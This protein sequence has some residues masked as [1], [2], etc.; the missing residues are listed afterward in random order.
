MLLTPPLPRRFPTATPAPIELLVGVEAPSS[1]SSAIPE[2]AFSLSDSFFPLLGQA[3][4]DVSAPHPAAPSP[5]PSS[6]GSR[7][8]GDGPAAHTRRASSH[9]APA[10]PGTDNVSSALPDPTRP[11]GPRPSQLDSHVDGPAAR[12]RH[13]SSLR[14]SSLPS[15]DTSV[16]PGPT[17]PAGPRPIQLVSPAILAPQSSSVP[18]LVKPSDS[19][20]HI[21]EPRVDGEPDSS[22]GAT[23]PRL[24]RQHVYHEEVWMATGVLQL[25]RGTPP[26]DTAE[27][28][29]R[30]QRRIA[31]MAAE[32]R[33]AFVEGHAFPLAIFTV[34]GTHPASPMGSTP[35]EIPAPSRRL[36]LIAHAHELGH[37]GVAKTVAKVRS[38]GY[39]WVG[40]DSDVAMITSRCVACIRDNLH[41]SHWHPAIA[42][43]IPTA[44]MERVHMD[45]LSLPRAAG[46]VP[47]EGIFLLVDAL[48]KWP[49]AIPFVSKGAEEIGMAYWSTVTTYGPP[50]VVISDNGA[51]FASANEILNAMSGIHG[52]NQRFTSRYR[53]QADGQAERFNRTII[54]VLRK[55]SGDT[56][57]L[58]H[59][60]LDTVLL[61]IR[62]AVHRSTRFSPF[63]LMFG[64]DW[65]PLR[66][67]HGLAL[68][69]E[70]DQDLIGD[71]SSLTGADRDSQRR[72]LVADP[73]VNEEIELALVNRSRLMRRQLDWTQR[74]RD[75]LKAAAV[76]QVAGQDASHRTVV[77]RLPKG[78]TVWVINEPR[79]NKID[80]L[81]HGPFTI[82][83]NQGG[84]ISSNY[85]LADPVSGGLLSRSV[86]RDKI[87]L[88]VN[89][90][91]T[92]RQ[93]ELFAGE[94]IEALI[95][96][97]D[98][99][100]PGPMP[101]GAAQGGSN[102]PGE[103]AVKEVLE[104]RSLRGVQELL[105][106]WVGYETPTWE[107]SSTFEPEIAA[108]LL[109][110]M[111][112]R[113]RPPRRP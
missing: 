71:S 26:E 94:E 33:A 57:Q 74:A 99:V 66:E 3:S 29:Q 8:L 100:E 112:A 64:R 111:A 92:R 11:A 14:A 104:A 109:R 17:Q 18:S 82:E 63:Q 2:S 45:L 98:H 46:P 65:N 25:L 36:A 108:E 6:L 48:S 40:L 34:P 51:E 43:P 55:L 28:P 9:R 113:S 58:W 107:P 83:A 76:S 39:W 106:R 38:A 69:W 21:P 59:T 89:I 88:S 49:V 12:T 60:W 30:F 44:I 81:F 7:S 42:L 54:A 96:R 105:V 90:P 72:I 62:T 20:G 61:V 13:A 67:F 23:P 97:L 103:F 102:A 35:L 86:P 50:R 75:N 70:I 4:V 37:F 110:R 41:S 24:L 77:D 91:L 27:V 84:E 68:Q 10:L 87:Y 101:P 53:P 56:P 93:A 47:Y 31:R 85:I 80:H 32:H 16:F 52:I 78:S 79:G 95:R 19:H 15:P 1:L 22:R 73:A 5:P